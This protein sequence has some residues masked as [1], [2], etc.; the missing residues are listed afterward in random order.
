[1]PTLM[2]HHDVKD[3]DHWLASPKRDGKMVQS[4]TLFLSQ[5]LMIWSQRSSVISMGFSTTTCLPHWRRQRQA[6]ELVVVHIV[7]CRPRF[8][9]QIEGL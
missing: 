4:L 2:A 7:V 3:T 5:A 9:P 6:L 8:R 1:M